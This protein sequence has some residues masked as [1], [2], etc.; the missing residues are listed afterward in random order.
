MPP[1]KLQMPVNGDASS[2]W[3]MKRWPLVLPVHAGPYFWVFKKDAVEGS[4]V[5]WDKIDDIV[6]N[7]TIGHSSHCAM[8][9]CL[10]SPR[11]YN[12]LTVRSVKGAAGV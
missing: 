6:T 9:L 12:G 11:R 8:T 7:W 5:N 4:V 10:R 2:A 1:T 3:E